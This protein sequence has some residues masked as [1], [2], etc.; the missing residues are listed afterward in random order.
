[1]NDVEI[2]KLIGVVRSLYPAQRFDDSPSNVLH[3]WSAVVSDLGYDEAREAVVRIARR[4]GTWCAPGDV[5]REVAHA[6]HVLSPDVDMLLADVREVASHDGVGRSL[7]HPAAQRAYTSVGGAQSI[8]RLDAYGLQRLRKAIS[9][10]CEREDARVLEDV[11]PPPRPALLPIREQIVE[12]ERAQLAKALPAAPANA[13][14][15]TADE[16][17]RMREEF[18]SVEQ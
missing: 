7:L 4:G 9:E 16:L 13:H 5:R 3:A 8:R 17:R 15:E 1:M 10:Q 18:G 11:L 2:G 6:R 14:P 12:L